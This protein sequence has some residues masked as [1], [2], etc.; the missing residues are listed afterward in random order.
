LIGSVRG[1]PAPRVDHDG[2]RKEAMTVS[3][4]IAADVLRETFL[5]TVVEGTR[6]QKGL[7]HR[8]CQQ[9]SLS[10][11]STR[12]LRQADCVTVTTGPLSIGLAAYRSTAG[13]ARLVHEFLLRPRIRPVQAAA[14]TDLLLTM[15]EVLASR[16]RIERLVIVAG[17]GVPDSIFE[18]HGYIALLRDS[19]G[20]WRQKTLDD[21]GVT[22]FREGE[23]V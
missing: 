12:V 2:V 15:L 5:V 14:A 20:V 10:R 18:R 4:W 11:T 3:S 19:S 8:L 17:S 13:N 9:Y 6:A 21:A 23:D 22:G 7:L 16:D 1:R